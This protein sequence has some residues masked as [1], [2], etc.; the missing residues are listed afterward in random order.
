V[1][2]HPVAEVQMDPAGKLQSVHILFT[3]DWRP[4]H[5]V[6]VGLHLADEPVPVLE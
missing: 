3:T 1:V 5:G 4:V 2:A 6:M